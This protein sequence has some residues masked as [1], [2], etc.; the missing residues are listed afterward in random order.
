MHRVALT[1]WR[2]K[3]TILIASGLLTLIIFGLQYTRVEENNRFDPKEERQAQVIADAL[4][5]SMN[6]KFI[7]AVK[8]S[9]NTRNVK[10][11]TETNADVAPKLEHDDL[12]KRQVDEK[13]ADTLETEQQLGIPYVNLDGKNP[14]VP[15]QRI[16]HLDLKGAPPLIS[17]FKQIF[18]LIK[19]MGATGILLGSS[20]SVEN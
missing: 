7:D 19:N 8:H 14:Y 12:A 1:T 4:I 18:P 20:L 9:K 10:V 5:R 13:S 11:S 17:Y 3:T 2:K 16:V 15:K 6:V